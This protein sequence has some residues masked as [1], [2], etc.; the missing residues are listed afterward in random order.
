[1]RVRLIE[2]RADATK[3]SGLPDQNSRPIM[4]VS[5]LLR[6][7]GVSFSWR[8]PSGRY[9][10]QKSPRAAGAVCQI[11]R[12]MDCLTCLDHSD[13]VLNGL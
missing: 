10:D 6:P 12:L 2:T 11:L 13:A 3:T 9:S 8:N 1:M 5:P 4:P 7:P